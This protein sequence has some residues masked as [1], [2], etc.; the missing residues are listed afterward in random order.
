MAQS[1]KL[2]LDGV[3]FTLDDCNDTRFYVFESDEQEGT[4]TISFDVA[5]QK[6]NYLDEVVHLAFRINPHETG[7][8]GVTELIGCVFHVDDIQEA[9]EREDTCYIFEHEPI[10]RYTFKIVEIAEQKVH[11]Q[12][13]GI[14][15]V[16]GY[17]V[18]YKTAPFSGDFWLD[19]E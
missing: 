1:G 17:S 12:F 13:E 2:I 9:D 6:E 8:V 5:F 10:E 19:C 3:N 11:I 7:K 16:D 18:P 14:A 4:I 15:V